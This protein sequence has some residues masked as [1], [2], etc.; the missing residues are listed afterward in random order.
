MSYITHRLFIIAIF[1]IC[2]LSPVLGQLIS[3]R[4]SAVKTIEV[5]PETEKSTALP[6]NMQY[7]GIKGSSPVA[8]ATKPSINSARPLKRFEVSSLN[9]NLPSRS[10]T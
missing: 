9:T 8:P 7:V 2:S 10:Q 1:T 6:Y 4:E 5:L 3:R